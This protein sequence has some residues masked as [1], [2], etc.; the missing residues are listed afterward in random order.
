MQKSLKIALVIVLSLAIV[1][2]SVGSPKK[3]YAVTDNHVF[4]FY[5]DPQLVPDM[6]FAQTALTKYVED[7]NYILAKNTKHQFTF[8]PS[9]DIILTTTNPASGSGGA[10]LPTSGYDVWAYAVKSTQSYSYGGY[11]S[12]DSSGAAALLD[13]HWV[14]LYDPEVLSAGTAQMRDYWIQIDHMLHEFAHATGAG[15]GEYYNLSTV[16]DATGVTPLLNINSMD[17]NDSFWSDKQDFMA[18][19]LM[20][21]TYDQGPNRPVS[22][23]ALLDTVKFSNLTAAVMNGFY[24]I[25]VP[26]PPLPDMDHIVIRVVDQ[27]TG[28]A[29]PGAAVKMWNVRTFSPYYSELRAD[30]VADANGELVVSWGTGGYYNNYEHLKLIK[31]YDNNGKA[32]VKYFSTY[33][34]N[35]V[36]LIN[37]L[38]QVVITVAVGDV[39]APSASLTNPSQGALLTGTIALAA[40]ATDDTGVSKVEFYRDNGVLLGTDVAAPY[41]INWV[42][43]SEV[44]GSH[45]LYSRAYDLAGNANSSTSVT[46]TVKD[47]VAPTT[48]ITGPIEGSVL[49]RRWGININ[50]V[51]ADNV[52]VAR[53]EFYVNGALKCTDTTS[54]YVCP[55]TVPNSKGT[56]LLQTKAYDAAN[57]MGLSP[58]V[59]VS[60]K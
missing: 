21:N 19:P 20:R 8:N 31:A 36:K 22:R 28:N 59:S 2:P 44:P 10:D 5:L 40:T 50:A 16:N 55:W 3:A 57:N 53:V 48:T 54:Q 12:L 45:T 4:K 34:A 18:D 38:D 11:S 49:T 52:G 39:T 41:S 14:Q 1:A 13:F 58:I 37:G 56:Y 51:A 7:M 30:S 60:S 42:T 24:R 43:N 6:N 29:V 26:L 17:P 15:I 23:A 9:T 33:D 32:V 27:A 46:V 35:I 25:P 47:Q